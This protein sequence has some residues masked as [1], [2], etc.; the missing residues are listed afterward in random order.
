MRTE[1]GGAGPT[2]MPP[3]PVRR[4]SP[5]LA[6]PNPPAGIERAERQPKV[7]RMDALGNPAATPFLPVANS[8]IS[9]YQ[10]TPPQPVDILRQRAINSGLYTPQ[11]IEQIR[12]LP[13]LVNVPVPGGRASYNAN[14]NVMNFPP[15]YFDAGYDQAAADADMQHELA[16]YFDYSNGNPSQRPGWAPAANQG[17]GA[18]FPGVGAKPILSGPWGT[19]GGPREQYA[20][21]GEEPQAFP[22]LRQYYP[23]FTDQA[24]QGGG[25]TRLNPIRN[26]PFE[27][28]GGIPGA[29]LYRRGAQV[30]GY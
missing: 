7:A 28:V 19:W 2:P 23:Q 3:A 29:M 13:I 22:Q 21:I 5:I 26:W 24:Y 20:Y 14:Q 9:P 16:H 17:T 1:D 6:K 30:P 4:T 27:P 10:A 25:V 8:P 18:N 15:G 11:A 12:N